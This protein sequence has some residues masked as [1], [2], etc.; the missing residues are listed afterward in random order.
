MLDLF[1]Q[2]G[3]NIVGTLS[4]PL[5]RQ[6]TICCLFFQFVQERRTI[7]DAFFPADSAHENSSNA[8]KKDAAFRVI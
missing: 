5:T 3:K 4:V 2:T 8:R 1:K 6:A 7:A